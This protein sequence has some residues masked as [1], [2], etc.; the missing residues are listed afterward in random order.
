M[1][2]MTRPVEMSDQRIAGARLNSPELAMLDHSKLQLAVVD[3]VKHSLEV[4][5]SKNDVADNED[6]TWDLWAIDG[7][8]DGKVNSP[9]KNSTIPPPPS[10]S[11]D[12]SQVDINASFAAVPNEV[13]FD[14]PRGTGE[15]PQPAKFNLKVMSNPWAQTYADTV[16]SVKGL[17][18]CRHSCPGAKAG[19]WVFDHEDEKRIYVDLKTVAER[20]NHA[21]DEDVQKVVFECP[22]Q[23][24]CHFVAVNAKGFEKAFIDIVK[25]QVPG[26]DGW[27]N[28]APDDT[29]VANRCRAMV[30]IVLHSELLVPNGGR[31]M[32]GLGRISW[33]GAYAVTRHFAAHHK[34]QFEEWPQ[35][36]KF[37]LLVGKNNI[38]IRAKRRVVQ[39]GTKVARARRRGG[40]PK[41]EHDGLLDDGTGAG[42]KTDGTAM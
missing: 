19:K 31:C 36:A 25:N 32:E 15:P 35:A 22:I 42:G 6:L 24:C 16:F 38:L 4:L 30:D 8:R 3:L 1:K 26:F 34:D 40:A 27:D 5:P 18:A 41:G 17:L 33:N 29:A 23:G 37:G 13:V 28:Y 21:R 11:V 7:L 39:N 2:S 10:T 14:S 9:Q 12:W 20:K